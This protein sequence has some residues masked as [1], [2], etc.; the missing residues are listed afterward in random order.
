MCVE[1]SVSYGVDT[2]DVEN[3]SGDDESEAVKY[4]GQSSFEPV[5]TDAIACSIR[6]RAKRTTARFIVILNSLG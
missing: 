5:A 4:V 3:G 6:R 2:G 1:P